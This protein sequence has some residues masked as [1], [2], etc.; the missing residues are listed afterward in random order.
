M[1]YSKLLELST[2]EIINNNRKVCQIIPVPTGRIDKISLYLESVIDLNLIGNET[3]I[4]VE[5]YEVDEQYL[6]IGVPLVSDKKEIS[7][8]TSPSFYNFMIISNTPTIVA[9][10]VSTEGDQRN[11]I[12]WSYVSSN[13]IGEPMGINDGGSG[14]KQDF[15]RKMSYVAFSY[16]PNAVNLDDERP[17]INLDSN[18]TD[19]R[20]DVNPDIVQTALIQPGK[21]DNILS[22]TRD[23]F[24][25]M[26]L[27]QSAIIGDTVAIDF[28]Q[29]VITLV[30]DQSGSM[31][32]ND[33]DGLRFEF[34]NK[35]IDEITESLEN[36]SYQSKYYL[37][38]GGRS[39]SNTW[40]SIDPWHSGFIEINSEKEY[41]VKLSIK[42]NFAKL[43]VYDG[44]NLLGEFSSEI[45]HNFLNFNSLNEA[46]IGKP[47]GNYSDGSSIYAS[48]KNVKVNSNYPVEHT[49]FE[50]D[51]SSDLGWNFD[52][53]SRAQF[54]SGELLITTLCGTNQ[55]GT[56]YL[57]SSSG[58]DFILS[59]KLKVN[60]AN[61]CYDMLI[62]VCNGRNLGY[63]G[64]PAGIWIQLGFEKPIL[65][66]ARYS[67][68]KF[69]GRQIARMRMLL[70][71][72]SQNGTFLKNVTIARNGVVIY[73]GLGEQ[74]IDRG[75]PGFPLDTDISYLYSIYSIDGYGN[76][77]ELKTAIAAP[78]PSPV[79]P[80]GCAGFVVKEEIIKDSDYD[81]GK[82]RIKISW[83]HPTLNNDAIKYNR[84][85]IIRRDDRFAESVLDGIVVLEA[86]ENSSS[87]KSP[88][89]DFN[90]IGFDKTKYPCAGIS[91]Y[92]TIFT[93]NQYG[94]KCIL[95]NSRKSSVLIS[96]SDKPWNKGYCPIP[97]SYDPTVPSPPSSPV[98]ISSNS[99]IK[100]NWGS[101]VGAKRYEIYCGHYDYPL[102]GID[103]K[104]GKRIYTTILSLNSDQVVVDPIYNGSA[105]EFIHRNLDNYQPYYYVIVSYDAVGNI[106][107]GVQILGRPDDTNQ[108][109]IPPNSPE[110]FS[111]KAYNETS[112]KLTWKLPLPD[113][114][115]VTAYFGEK[116][117]I[118]CLATFS[119]DDI[120]KTSAKLEIEETQRVTEGF[121]IGK[122]PTKTIIDLL[123]EQQYITLE[124]QRINQI[125]YNVS[126]EQ[127]IQ[128]E[129][130]YYKDLDKKAKSRE[131]ESDT[132]SNKDPE[133]QNVEETNTNTNNSKFYI[134]PITKN[135]I[136]DPVSAIEFSKSPSSDYNTATASISSTS[137]MLTLNLMKEGYSTIRPSIVVKDRD[138]GEIITSVHGENGSL[139]LINPFNIYIKDDPPKKITRRVRWLNSCCCPIDQN[140]CSYSNG[141]P[142]QCLNLDVASDGIGWV[143]EEVAGTY[144]MLGDYFSFIVELTWQDL[145]IN[146]PIPVTIRLL[147]AKTGTPTTIATLQGSS[148]GNV[149]T[150]NSQLEDQEIIDR[151][152]NPSG[153][154]ERK[155]VIRAN[156][157]SQEIPGEYII[158]VTANY[159]GYGRRET[160]PIYFEHP[161][162]IDIISTPFIPNG[163]DI[164]EQQ[165]LVYLGDPT[166]PIENKIPISDGTIV[167]W[168][169]IPGARFKNTRPFYSKGNLSGTGIKSSTTNGI[170]RNVFFGPGT[171]IEPFKCSEAADPC[172]EY[173]WYT[174]RAEIS[175]LG[176]KRIGYNVIYEN[177]TV[178]ANDESGLNRI[179]IRP[180]KDN[181]PSFS[182]DII[183][184]D[185]E[186]ESLWEVVAVPRLDGDVKD[187]HSGSYFHQAITSIGGLVPDLPNGTIITLYINA[188]MGSESDG[189]SISQKGIDI[190]RNAGMVEIKT[191]LTKGEYV[192]TNYIKSTIINGKAQ[193]YIRLN[194]LSIGKIIDTP[195]EEKN[196]IIY[197]TAPVWIPS[198]LIYSI[199]ATCSITVRGKNIVFWGGGRSLESSTPPCWLSFSEPLGIYSSRVQSEDGINQG[200]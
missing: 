89:Y 176:V 174:I 23:D 119:D 99:I 172:H 106:S 169:I 95:Q 81:V 19:I 43:S 96:E 67:I 6:P 47:S 164:A 118:L 18:S 139:K 156:I 105:T 146:D 74:F 191:D 92:Y 161:L 184:S 2:S 68:L 70:N 49:I 138:T 148:N 159:N 57:S 71:E 116:I 33:K 77:S 197:G 113:M 186:S 48:I 135:I 79:F 5:I 198:P 20:P 150:V 90:D 124:N 133:I 97:P 35:L 56:R 160:L 102:P 121:D 86:D 110:N 31:T 125:I 183:P 178:G 168:E 66:S 170:A 41:D 11:W 10:V 91:Y 163:V 83:I 30:V 88:F 145:P 130:D 27:F 137:D 123:G 8:I 128:Q 144:A 62:G 64:N 117:N 177:P 37:S 7:Y 180:I 122:I 109:T 136:I 13:N 158:E 120:S 94:I 12:K 55:I 193:F 187:N 181:Q 63:N 194:A 17:N 165:A 4:L 98:V 153:T 195:L 189:V 188:Y 182:S 143:C 59:S 111:A 129:S 142:T 108:N 25:K 173:E 34:L 82:R 155:S 39:E 100:L 24:K 9:I 78:H 179:F 75:S 141:D 162:N 60:F 84:I 147:D 114:R 21:Q 126:K 51:F 22:S 104:T 140:S 171:D 175:S 65:S 73:E 61:G 69:R 199:T 134:D 46:I 93:E 1:T 50:D 44:P 107:D 85:Y 52:D 157:P 45:P 190:I 36:A 192:K 196:N 152:G 101:S 127:N 166:W 154:N 149:I 151:A 103:S 3:N 58:Q 38:I 15:Y 26:D 115:S 16:V 42:N 185:G 76:R 87:F 14:W 40:S 72:D 53:H 112:I 200:P 32:W 131:N 132:I 28:G 167:K 80:A 29:Y 54:V